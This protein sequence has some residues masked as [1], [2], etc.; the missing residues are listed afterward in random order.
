[1]SNEAIILVAGTIIILPF[2]Y[3]LIKTIQEG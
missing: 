3:E 2:I 1:M